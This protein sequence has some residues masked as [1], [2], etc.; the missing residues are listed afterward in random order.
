M[1]AIIA[2]GGTGS[3]LGILTKNTNKHLINVYCRQ[4]IFYPLRTLINAGITEIM[5]ITGKEH[6]G[7]FMN[8]LGSGKE[9]NVNF[10]YKIQ[11][12]SD[13]IAGA[14]SLAKDFIGKDPFVTILGDNLFEDNF[15][16]QVKEFEK[17]HSRAKVF[18]KEVTDPNRFGVVQFFEG[19]ISNIIE[20]PKQFVSS[21]VVTGIY[22]FNNSVWH[23]I[24]NLQPSGRGELEVSDL[25]RWYLENDLLDYERLSGFW[26]DMGTVESLFSASEFVKNNHEKFI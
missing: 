17:N 3:R 23:V 14:I 12:E 13:G 6:C 11:E 4:M 25:S 22:F 19:H 16:K 9:F 15:S 1:K 20:K 18:L 10:V 7:S 8:L 2:S 24:K 26:S 21:S 5:I